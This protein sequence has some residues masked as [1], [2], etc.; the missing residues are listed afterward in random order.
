MNIAIIPARLHSK[1]IKEKNIKLF[2]GKPIISYVIKTLLSTKLFD[3]IIVSTDSKKIKKIAEKYGAKVPFIRGKRLANDYTPTREVIVDA[4]KQLE[5]KKIKFSNICCIYSTSIL[6]DKLNL[7][8]AHNIFLKNKKKYIFGA[9]RYAHPIERSFYIDSSN[10]ISPYN[11][12]NF[13]KRTQ[14]LQSAYYDAGQFYFGT[15]ETFL[16]GTNIFSNSAYP[17][18]LNHNHISDIDNHED[19]SDVEIKYKLI[20]RLKKN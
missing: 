4:I 15:K 18:I 6:I 7:I 17:I 19:W 16:N 11:K 9:C 10:N 3:Q 1:R 8:H 14:D 12:K 20:K 13:K 2:L 5:R